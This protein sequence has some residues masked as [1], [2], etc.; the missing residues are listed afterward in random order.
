MARFV[1]S[2]W[3]VAFALLAASCGEQTKTQTPSFAT[4]PAAFV[5]PKL[6]IGQTVVRYVDLLNQGSGDLVIT[7]ISLRDE[8]S[9]GEFSIFSAD[10]D[11]L[12]P[13]PDR[14]TLAPEGSHRIAVQ[15]VPSDDAE[16]SGRVE[17]ATNDPGA[18]TYAIPIQAGEQAGEI[19]VT[20]RTLDF[21]RVEIGG[22]V[23]RQ[24]T[25]ANTGLSDLVI[26]RFS[27]EG[28]EDF[29]IRIGERELLGDALDDSI[30]IAPSESITPT[31]TFAPESALRADS[32]L[33][34]ESNA[35][36]A[37][38][39]TVGLVANGAVPCLAVNP[40]SLDFSAGLLV[41]SLDA[42]TPNVLPL[43]LESCGTASVRVERIEFQGGMG[44]F[45]AIDLPMVDPGAPLFQLPAA[46]PDE[47]APS[48]QFDVGF[49]PLEVQAYGGQVLVHSN[50]PESP[51]IVDVFGRGVDNQCPVP[52]ADETLYQVPPLDLITLDGTP[53]M[54]PG[55][56]VERWEWTVVERPD[57]SV[58]E[59]VEQFEDP[60]RP[61]DGGPEDDPT[62][63]TA[64]FFVD[65]AGRYTV[66]LRVV[67]NLGQGSCAPPVATVTI[68]A[69]PEKDLHIQLVWSTPD[70]PDES[71][72]F[73]TDIDL[74]F[75]HERGGDG[76]ANAANG[77]D[78]YFRNKTPDWGAQGDVSD[79]PSLD[80]DDTNGAGPENVN[81]ASPEIG[82][83]YDVAAIYFRNESTFGDAMN[84]PRQQHPSYVT[85]RIFAR[86]E[87]LTEFI[88]RELNGLRQLWHVASIRWC[89]DAGD[90]ARCPEI[91]VQD[92]LFA[93]GEYQTE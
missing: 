48:R 81:L 4:D 77:F 65:L 7:D 79:N 30:T 83:T 3:L 92:Q 26:T 57:G 10:G 53:S 15:Y 43:T 59:P 84:D 69:V 44:T 75:R 28:R 32:D 35:V 88:G 12:L 63:P 91:T 24:L 42:E 66:E 22:S 82:V 74:H 86:G 11:E 38:S 47:A 85:A 37:P 72:E 5:F 87:L 41:D 60:R 46:D 23:E 1:Q 34:I 39:I 49:W 56:R 40:E 45:A 50:S 31:V 33:V 2:L 89:E 93:E 51:N 21:G 6:Q 58:S 16:D 52:I 71:D 20:P 29:S 80:I 19:V 62:T 64:Q 78:C 68:E 17:L 36:N 67:D 8:S 54:D 9:A 55:G 25:I 76:W 13:V 70:D 90:V 18:A 27:I 14:I 61:A 73:G